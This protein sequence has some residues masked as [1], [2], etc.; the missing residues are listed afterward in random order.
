[1]II[2]AI[3][4]THARWQNLQIPECDILISCGDY[5]YKGERELIKS[6]HE[7]LNKQPAKHVISL[8]GNHELYVE[9]NWYESKNIA[10]TACPRVHF[11]DHHLLEIEG[12]KIFCSSFTPTFNNWAWNLDRGEDIK[13]IWDGIPEDI[14]VLATHGPPAGILDV[15][16]RADGITPKES[17]GCHDLMDKVLKCKNLKYHFFGHIHGSHGYREFMGKKFF[18][19]SICDEIYMPSHPI[20]VL[21]I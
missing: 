17:V 3:S 21:E 11:V 8:Q 9:K 20:T 10:E 6:F 15:V 19:C 7:W 18:N 16:Y 14:D 2:T 13:T 12:L 1:M 4:D 5:S